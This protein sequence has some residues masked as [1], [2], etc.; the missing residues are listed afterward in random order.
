MIWGIL[1]EYF[2]LSTLYVPTPLSSPE[3]PYSHSSPAN[4]Y[5]NSTIFL[6]QFS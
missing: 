2:H 4:P 6:S 5:T 3:E 1:R